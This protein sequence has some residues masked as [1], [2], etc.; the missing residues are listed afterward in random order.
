[1]EQYNTFVSSRGLL[2]ICD[3]RN[4]NPR[5][6]SAIIDF[7]E[8]NKLRHGGSIYVCQDAIG[9]FAAHILESIKTP[10]VLVSGDSDMPLTSDVQGF[11]A[12]L[13]SE[14]LMAWYAQNL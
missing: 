6:S 11:E 3:I 9:L 4:T 10:F 13:N 5:S 1:M 12:I 8:H 7:S 2:K 14:Y